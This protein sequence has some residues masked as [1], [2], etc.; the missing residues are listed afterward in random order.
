[1]QKFLWKRFQ[2]QIFIGM[3]TLLAKNA[4]DPISKIFALHKCG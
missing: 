3:K 2:E 1:M 4:I